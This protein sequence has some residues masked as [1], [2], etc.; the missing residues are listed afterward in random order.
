MWN[1]DWDLRPVVPICG[2]DWPWPAVRKK[3]FALHRQAF[4]PVAPVWP[5]VDAATA[6]APSDR[7]GVPD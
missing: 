3:G 1:T 6:A 2:L 7:V 4:P 5:T